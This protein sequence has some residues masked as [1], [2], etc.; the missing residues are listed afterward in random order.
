MAAAA[1][2]NAPMTLVFDMRTLLFVG[3]V[4]ALACTVMLWSSRGLHASSKG[5]LRWA[6]GS[7]LM[8]GLALGA[9]ALR[10]AIPDLISAPHAEPP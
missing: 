3:S 7:Q 9:V 6:A 4:S 2:P 10:G 5:A 8:F 1:W